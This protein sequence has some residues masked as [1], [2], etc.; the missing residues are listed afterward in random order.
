ME[1]LK[2]ALAC[3]WCPPEVGGV[4]THI[5]YFSENLVQ[6]GHEVE[7][8]THKNMNSTAGKEDGSILYHR[9]RGFVLNR[10]G[11]TV[12]PRAIWEVREILKKGGYDIVHGHGVTSPISAAAC[13]YAKKNGGAATILTNHSLLR[14]FK[15]NFV[16]KTVLKPLLSSADKV[17]AVSRSVAEETERM[18]G[19]D[20]VIIP[21]GVNLR[22]SMVGC[23]EGMSVTT[24]S[25]LVKKKNI[26]DLVKISP[27]L[28]EE[29]PDLKF[30]IVGNGPEKKTIQREI[31]A[32]GSEERFNLVDSVPHEEVYRYLAGSSV[33]VLPSSDEAF[34]I[35]LLE[36]MACSIPVVAKNGSGASDIVVHGENGYLAD[37]LDELKRFTRELLQDPLKRKA[38]GCRGRRT[39]KRFDWARVSDQVV[40]VYRD[41]LS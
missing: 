18:W 29:F 5:R 20:A 1:T 14:S 36:A 24:I 33:F 38:M 31:R 13:L 4:E 41:V 16:A 32:Q 25:R 17:I 35:S 37:D 9:V 12:D 26:I 15:P 27:L 2:I 7:I 3:D 10:Q 8:I 39:A 28:L 40:D 23:P 6:R 34:G 11:V 30:T 22:E 19:K 21:N